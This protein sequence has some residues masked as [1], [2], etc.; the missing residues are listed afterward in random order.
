MHRSTILM[1]SLWPLAVAFLMSIGPAA[2][3]TYICKV[4]TERVTDLYNVKYLELD[5]QSRRSRI[6]NESSWLDGHNFSKSES[7]SIGMKYYWEQK[8]DW[9]PKWGAGSDTV[10]FT[11][12]IKPNNKVIISGKRSQG[13]SWVFTNNCKVQ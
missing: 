3:E 2:A 8:I 11:A 4:T 5:I 9:N 6:G 10:R 7:T 1:K 12:L 13:A